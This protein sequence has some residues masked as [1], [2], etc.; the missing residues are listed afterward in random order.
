MPRLRVENA[1]NGNLLG[2]N[3]NAVKGGKTGALAASRIAGP[4]LRPRAVLGDLTKITAASSNQVPSRQMVEKKP[5]ASALPK[6]KVLASKLKENVIEKEKPVAVKK[7]E[8]VVEPEA[9][10]ST[11]QLPVEDIDTDRENPQLVSYYAKDI[12]RHLRQLETE[13]C[14]KSNYMDGYQIRPTMRTILVDWLVDVHGRFKMLQETLYLTVAVMDSFLQVDSTITRRDLQLVGITAMLIAA[15]FEETWAPEI[16][17]FVYMSDKA[18]TNQDVLKM[19]CRILQTLDYR[20]GRPLPLHFL[21]RN[22][23]AASQILEQ[24]D[25]LHHTLSKYLMELTLPEYSFSC[26]LPSE[27]AAAALC[28]SLRILDENE[29]EPNEL[30]N[31]SMVFYS[32]YTRESLEPLMDKLCSLLVTSEASKFQAV[33]KKYM[34]SKL[35]NISTIPH[36]KSSLVTSMAKKA[37]A[38]AKN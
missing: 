14:I 13:Y 23:Q 35:Y 22:T 16:N 2:G 8:P 11:N 6:P 21:R 36:L 3:I 26:Y 12:Y 37:A 15:K 18:Y 5:V 4:N 32:G 31:A 25:V 1:Q 28:L 9:S 20:L 38:G 10:Y 19:E 33:R 34:S 24:V 27:L 17:D 29:T 30:W 7:P